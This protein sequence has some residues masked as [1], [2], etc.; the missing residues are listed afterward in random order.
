MGKALAE[1]VIEKGGYVIGTFRQAAQVENFNNRYKDRALAVELD[2]TQP[3]QIQQAF[4]A[5]KQQVGSLDV[6]VNNAGFGFAGAI[7]EASDEEIRAV[8]EAN[9]FGTVQVTKAALPIFRK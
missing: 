3:G 9:F 8:F 6:L 7:E 1:A 2:I 4:H 5:M